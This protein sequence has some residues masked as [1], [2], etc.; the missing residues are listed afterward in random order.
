MQQNLHYI[1]SIT[2]KR[3]RIKLLSVMAATILIPF[4]ELVGIGAIFS[5]IT[6]VTDPEIVNSS[7]WVIRIKTMFSIESDRRFLVIYGFGVLVVFIL[8]NL[9]MA[10]YVWLRTW[11]SANLSANLASRLIDTYLH[12]PYEFHLRNNTAV[13]LKNVNSE[14]H[15]IV[16]GFLLPFINIFSSTIT[17]SSVLI[18]LLWYDP[19]ITMIAIIVMGGSYGSVFALFRKYLKR[20]GQHR[21]QLNTDRY[22]YTAQSLSGVKEII[23][24]GRHS[25]FL[26]RC[27]KTF[28][29]LAHLSVIT[30]ILS[31]T[32]RLLLEILVFGGI[33]LLFLFNLVYRDVGAIQGLSIIGLYAVA[34]YRLMPYLD[35]LL[36]SANSIRFN[37]AAIQNIHS[38]LLVSD[39]TVQ[40]SVVNSKPVSFRT[41]LRL[42]NISFAYL[43]SKNDVLSDVSLA[44]KRYDSVAF[45]GQSGAG[46]STVINILLGLLTAVKGEMTVDG[47]PIT[48]TNKREWQNNVGFVPQNIYLFDD[49]ILRN[50]AFGLP[51]EQVDQNAVV[52]AARLAHIHH[53]ISRELKDQYDTK[54]GERGVRLSGGQIQRI[55]IARALYNNP[56]LLVFDEPTSSLDAITQ[57]LI[58]EMIESLGSQ[59]TI[60]AISHNISTIE[61]CDRIFLMDDG[62]LIAQGNYG[63]LAENNAI[64]RRLAKIQDPN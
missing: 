62:K 32:P 37:E 46:K 49:T 21:V 43:G 50:I 64:F 30:T 12:S 20:L 17:L 19:L 3:D 39:N 38:H 53:F 40:Q 24:L 15:L 26:N 47:V 61:H 41:E 31:Q 48:E 11:F 13:L 2:T 6:I 14:S 18:A 27:I 59:K 51:D 25:Y 52:E 55:G 10:F 9:F 36:Q 16:T 29:K 33:I 63:D 22:Q 7:E 1:W 8:R 57:E 5:F 34:G 23:V 4:F 44:I 35:T 42:E 45:V 58:S 28:S 56:E 54:V 60:I